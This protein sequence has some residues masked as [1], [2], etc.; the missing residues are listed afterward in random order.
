MLT[1]RRLL[2][3]LLIATMLIVPAGGWAVWRA[4]AKPAPLRAYERLRL[5]M[6]LTEV[7]EAIGAP[8]GIHTD[9]SPAFLARRFPQHVRESGLPSET[10]EADWVHAKLTVERWSWEEYSINVA[11]DDDGKAVGY[12]LLQWPGEWPQPSF[13]DRLR[14]FVGL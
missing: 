3:G 7:E 1:R 12:Y 11:F 13:L 9:I 4:I 10:A 2:I 8:P 14:Q 5:G 6:T